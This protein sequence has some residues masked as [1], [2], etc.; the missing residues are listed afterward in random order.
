MLPTRDAL[1]ARAASLPPNPVA[2]EAFWDGDTSGWYVV[3]VAIYAEDLPGWRRYSEVSM[4]AL[5]GAGGD[6]RL[7]NGQTPPWPEAAVAHEVGEILAKKHGV[8]FFFASPN[9]PESDCPRWWDRDKGYPCRA[10]GLLLLQRDPCPWR[11]VCYQCHLAAA[12][13]ESRPV[14]NTRIQPRPSFASPVVDAGE[15]R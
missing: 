9:H 4:S 14:S 7:F 3:L 11:G 10:C 15:M 13:V 2:F 8:E 6:I 12:K 5:Q 1:L